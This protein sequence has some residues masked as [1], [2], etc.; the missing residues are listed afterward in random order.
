MILKRTLLWR[1]LPVSTAAL[2]PA[3]LL[4]YAVWRNV[5]AQ[6]GSG[7]AARTQFENGF[8]DALVTYE[9]ELLQ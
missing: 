6:A 3:A 9:Q 4:L 7:R 5:I 1:R 2:F 8:G